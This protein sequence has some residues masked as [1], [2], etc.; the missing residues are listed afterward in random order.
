MAGKQR[1]SDENTATK[2]LFTRNLYQIDRQNHGK[3]KDVLDNF[4]Y[5]N[6]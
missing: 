3:L 2:V 4:G 5:K 1:K 6:R